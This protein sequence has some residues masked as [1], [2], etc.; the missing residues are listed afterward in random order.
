MAYSVGHVNNLKIDRSSRPN[1]MLATWNYSSS[2]SGKY[3]YFKD[4]KVIWYYSYYD[5][6]VKKTI[7]GQPTEVTI[8][9]IPNTTTFA[10]EYTIPSLG[11]T[12]R[13]INIWCSVT[14]EAGSGTVTKKD[15][16]GNKKDVSKDPMWEGTVSISNTFTVDYDVLEKPTTPSDL[17]IEVLNSQKIKVTLNNY[18]HESNHAKSVHLQVEVNGEVTPKTSLYK[19]NGQPKNPEDV[20]YNMTGNWTKGN[21]SW[22]SDN[23]MSPGS[24]YRYR[25]AGYQKERLGGDHSYYTGWSEKIYAKPKIP[26][27]EIFAQTAVLENGGYYANVVIRDKAN[28][29][30]SKIKGYAIQYSYNWEDLYYDRPEAGDEGV[31]GPIYIKKDDESLDGTTKLLHQENGYVYARIY[32]DDFAT[33]A[34]KSKTGT[35]WFRVAAISEGSD[36]RISDWPHKKADLYS[37]NGGKEPLAPTT[38]T[39]NPTYVDDENIIIHFNNNS[40]D[41]SFMTKYKLLLFLD[42][43]QNELIFPCAVAKDVKEEPSY[44]HNLGTLSNIIDTW[45][46]N[47]GI[48]KD[49]GQY[50]LQYQISTMGAFTGFSSSIHPETDQEHDGWSEYSTAKTI[51]I[52]RK[53]W[54]KFEHYEEEKWLWDPFD[55][56]YDT[57]N[58]AY[59]GTEFPQEVTSFPLF[60]GVVSGPEPQS[61]LE[62]Q[63]QIKSVDEYDTYDYDGS[64]KHINP[65]EII[66]STFSPPTKSYFEN[67]IANHC[68]VRINPWDITL[69]NGRK[70][71]LTVNVTMSS[72]LLA[73]LTHMFKMN[74]DDVEFMPDGDIIVDNDNYTCAITPSLDDSMEFEEG[75]EP[76]TLNDIVFHIFRRN[77]D[78]T[79]TEIASA[80]TDSMQLSV[81]DPHPALNGASYRIVGMSKLT[82][83]IQ[84][85]DIPGPEFDNKP[86]II[87]W[88]GESQN[89]DLIMN[90]EDET[91]DPD[92]LMWYGSGVQ[93]NML[94]LPYNIDASN[95]YDIDKELVNYIGRENPVSYYGTSKGES[96]N[97]STV[98]PKTST[99]IIYQLRRLSRYAGDCYV[100]EP[101]GT[102]FWANVTVS[103]NINHCDVTV[104]ISI[105]AT[106]VEGGI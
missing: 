83:Q 16:K 100:R 59:K 67:N 31:K 54:I 106:R 98:I 38:W 52:Y 32:I 45:F 27:G 7:P 21:Y 30:L 14:P 82:G 77:Y 104:P 39:D 79:I 40:V 89:Y 105:T 20:Y 91:P 71:V 56:R 8:T 18:T 49:K 15:S 44:E 95:K 88:D 84:F 36:E 81:N 102:G 99:D 57:T 29:D 41:G 69:V 2:T 12:V 24:V 23:A 35:V 92:N 3:K 55:F 1:I 13:T 5:K 78:G 74:Y 46:P 63:F 73:S 93:N 76:I 43:K 68:L 11:E 66:W 94:V 90:Y 4:F 19:K 80:L 58:T 72:G 10:S 48:N 87:Q 97:L 60:I 64:V 25:V 86:I 22:I 70:Y 6:G 101:N 37:Y 96:L 61:G 65:D 75:E 17:K 85:V 51:D 34:E 33:E 62:Y 9:R 103:F 50:T 42:E 28:K 53:P 47:M 26:K